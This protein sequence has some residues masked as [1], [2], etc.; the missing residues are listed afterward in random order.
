VRHWNEMSSRWHEHY[1]QGR[2]SYPVNAVRVADLPTSSVVLEVGAGTGKLTRV[3]VDEFAEVVAVEPDPQMRS[4]FTALCPGVALLAGAA[5]ALPVAQTSFDAVFVAEAFHW[6]D[7][8]LAVAEISRVLR[9]GGALV[10][11]WNRPSGRPEPPIAEVENLLEPLWPKDIDLP[12]D[13]DPS[14]FPYARD[15]PEA[16]ER[17]VFEPLQVSKFANI[18]TVGRDELVAFF[19]S[20]GWIGGLPEDESRALLD[21]VRSRLVHRDYRLPFETDVHWTRLA[22]G[23]GGQLGSSPP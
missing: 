10:L 19:G 20:M 8:Q 21:E 11:M 14:R 22:Q 4:W 18:R 12:L 6:F 7:H 3:L 9:P 13:L 15:W 5:E 17:S 1:A 23:R 16:F 2:P